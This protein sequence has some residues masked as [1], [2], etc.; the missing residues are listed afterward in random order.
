[1]PYQPCLTCQLFP[2]ESITTTRE[3]QGK[4]KKT[5]NSQKKL[6]KDKICLG[7]E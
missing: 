6:T 1:M 3:S 7:K 4:R 5:Q 2:P